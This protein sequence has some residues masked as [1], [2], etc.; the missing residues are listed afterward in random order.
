MK[1]CLRF[2]MFQR[3]NYNYL[4]ILPV[5]IIF[6]TP[7]I[8]QRMA[9]CKTD[10]CS[11]VNGKRPTIT[12]T[13]TDTITSIPND[14]YPKI[15]VLSLI[16]TK[17]TRIEEDDFSTAETIETILLQKNEINY[18][19]PNAFR[20]LFRL[21]ILNLQDNALTS[22][23]AP[24]FQHL[25]SLIEL[26]LIKNQLQNISRYAFVTLP[27]DKD[28]RVMLSG[29]PVQCRCDMLAFRQWLNVRSTGNI[30]FEIDD[31]KCKNVNDL[32]LLDVDED[33]FNC[34]EDDPSVFEDDQSC[35]SCQG[36][37]SPEMCDRQG[38]L[39]ECS[40]EEDQQPV[41]RTTLTYQSSGLTVKRTCDEYRAC[42]RQEGANK[43]S[44]VLENVLQKRMTCNYCCLGPLCKDDAYGGRLKGYTFYLKFSTSGATYTSEFGD[45][46][47]KTYRDMV[48]RLTE[49]V[50]EALDN[51]GVFELSE[52]SFS[53]P[54]L[55][56][57]FRL[58][59]NIFI[60]VSTDDTRNAIKSAL[61]EAIEKKPES[62]MKQLNVASVD[63]NFKA[64]MFCKPEIQTTSKGTFEWPEALVDET[65]EI[66]CPHKTLSRVLLQA[67]RKCV[68][69]NDRAIWMDSNL[70]ACPFASN[71]TRRLE[72]LTTEEITNDN[73][74]EVS[75]ELQMI[76][77]GAANFTQT[78]VNFAVNIVEGIVNLES[79]LNSREVINNT[80]ASVSYIIVVPREV[81]LEAE[82]KKQATTRLISSVNKM[83]TS[84]SLGDGDLL[85]VQP[86][87]AVAAVSIDPRNFSGV[88]FTTDSSKSGGD[89]LAGET[90][91]IRKGNIP[92]QQD[93]TMA[94]IVLPDGLFASL[95]PGDMTKANRVIFA[96][97]P[98]DK[99][100]S[101]FEK[102]RQGPSVNPTG[103]AGGDGSVAPSLPASNGGS[104]ITTKDGGDFT[105][106]DG[107]QGKVTTMI[108]SKIISASVPNV[109]IANLTDPV[110]IHLPHLKK[111]AVNP[112]CVFWRDNGAG[113]STDGCE[114]KEDVKDSY[115][116]CACNHLTNFALLMDVYERGADV[117]EADR[118]ALSLISYIGCGI[119]LL[120]LLLTLLTYFMFR[121]LRRDNPS[122][123]LV[124][125][126]IALAVTNLIF[127]VGMQD[128]TFK[129][130]ISCKAVAVMLHYFMLSALTWMAVEA[131]YMYL[132][133]VV[134]FKTYFTN[135]ILKCCFIGW[136]LPLVVVAITLG[137]NETENYGEL[138]SGI[139]WIRNPAFYAAFLAPVAVILLI[140]FAAF[141]LV[142]RQILGLSS[143]KLNK[144]DK[145]STMT[146]LRGAM[147][148]VILLG[149]TWVF[150]VFAI[151]RASVVFYYLFAITNSLQGLFIFI[152]YCLFKKDALSAWRRKLPCCETMDEKS[153]DR[154]SSK[155]ER[156]QFHVDKTHDQD[157]VTLLT[158]KQ[159]YTNPVS[160]NT[161]KHSM[162]TTNSSPNSN[163]D[164]KIKKRAMVSSDS[165]F[166]SSGGDENTRSS[167]SI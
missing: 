2:T 82:Q 97:Y 98:T 146:Q 152:F 49:A 143:R 160:N 108:N 136:G 63:V 26:N 85:I 69:V 153:G 70:E 42:L 32:P 156:T 138:A 75:K 59:C 40:L 119:S 131:F 31:L 149:L 142:L 144:S 21:K 14:L 141:G 62:L 57:Y 23:P 125:L 121:K 36:K 130:T 65:E 147:G 66:L 111:N 110:I 29:N 67:F 48:Q 122:K 129:N 5:L 68:K 34:D 133:L 8:G 51:L 109:I 3:K 60:R 105:V 43:E 33:D 9:Y 79:S 132:A 27:A 115:T 166:H 113:W 78:D 47:S 91:E 92:Q 1:W 158:F 116:T 30:K 140:N 157:Q 102:A 101:V 167:T 28:V 50:N 154:S 117:S 120:C 56:I 4:W 99:L 45:T 25:P 151:D 44:C 148:V 114:V 103:R 17:V 164:A 88:S 73:V 93:Q 61:S 96:V 58:A 35:R 137:I 165:G 118:V 106:T 37:A 94:T 24:M 81:L 112:R 54:G 90:V 124:N 162:S 64:P 16:R 77:S 39:Q 13:G 46:N 38:Q 52:I 12:C 7:V 86:N 18:I 139:C 71:V 104:S 83:T 145:T 11:C 76:T 22:I 55:T 20:N 80:L 128:Y 53:V 19:H 95:P 163:N 41:C 155:A 87:I 84:S 72:D 100:F 89:T 135:F 15:Q 107:A 134:V 126:C 74:L 127:L 123:I 10:A 161:V 159:G 150:A 6:T